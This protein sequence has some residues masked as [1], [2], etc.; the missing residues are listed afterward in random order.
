LGQEEASETGNSHETV[1]IQVANL[2][3]LLNKT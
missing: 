3:R 1:K 2:A